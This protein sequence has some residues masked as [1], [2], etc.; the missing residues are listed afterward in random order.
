MI[1][2]DEVCPKDT[3]EAKVVSSWVEI[4]IQG[5]GAE[6]VLLSKEDA[7]ALGEFLIRLSEDI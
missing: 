2:R 3:I 7:K 4:E 1:F 6:C 5:A